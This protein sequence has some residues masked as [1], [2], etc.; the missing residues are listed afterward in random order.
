MSIALVQSTHA[1]EI[2]STSQG[3]KVAFPAA[4]GAGNCLVSVL[5]GKKHP[6]PYPAGVTTSAGGSMDTNTPTPVVSDGTA[7][8]SLTLSQVAAPVVLTLASVANASAGS[9]VYTGTITGGGAN[10]F[11]GQTFTIAGFV[12]GANNGSFLCTA[13]SATTLTLSN[14]G[15]VAETHAATAT[16]QDSVYTGT[17]T[18]GGANAFAG[19]T[20]TISGFATGANNG[21]FACVASTT[22]TLILANASAVNETHAATAIS[23]G[24]NLWVT[25]TAFKSIDAKTSTGTLFTDASDCDL[26]SNFP[27]IYV[28][29]KSSGVLAGETILVKSAYAGPAVAGSQDAN[30]AKGVSIF[31]GG[32]NVVAMEFSG[33][34][35]AAT[36]QHQVTTANPARSGGSNIGAVNNLQV[37]CG[38]MKDANT[39]AASSGWTVVYADKT[40]SGQDHFVVAFKIVS[41]ADRAS[42]ANP[43]GYEMAVTTLNL[44]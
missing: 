43:L 6:D 4:V 44:T 29:K 19:R 2:Y 40:V 23:G 11:A 37:A 26:S 42:F 7:G 28:F 32:V 33:V 41:G 22:T 12:T 1:Q 39:F 15:G 36:E 34:T 18:G 9:T 25:S 21:T 3:L 24:S 8:L 30:G 31:D 10:A 27:A 5:I 13:S 16:D 35:G 20:F 17:I 38:Y 14:A